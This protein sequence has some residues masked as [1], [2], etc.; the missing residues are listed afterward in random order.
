MQLQIITLNRH[1][2]LSTGRISSIVTI[3][4]RNIN[5]GCGLKFIPVKCIMAWKAEQQP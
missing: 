2:M 4:M 3:E 1:E 5:C